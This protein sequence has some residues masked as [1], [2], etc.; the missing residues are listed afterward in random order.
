[1]FV[2]AGLIEEAM[3][4]AFIADIEDLNASGEFSASFVVQAA[5]G[6]KPIKFTF[7]LNTV[8]QPLLQL[9]RPPQVLRETASPSAICRDRDPFTT[10]DVASEGKG[11]LS[12]PTA[13]A[14]RKSS[15]LTQT[16]EPAQF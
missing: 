13:Q 11:E 3:A 12:W 7:T 15:F 4:N 1:M 2:D 14:C 10:W 9:S 16:T 8:P 6:T 5:V